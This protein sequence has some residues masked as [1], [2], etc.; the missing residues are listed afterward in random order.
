MEQE[1]ELNFWGEEWKDVVRFK[2]L[3]DTERYQISNYGR[4]RLWKPALKKWRIMKSACLTK[5]GTG[6]HYFTFKSNISW[7][8]TR[9]RAVHRLVAEAFLP[10]PSEFHK[11]V[12]HLDYNK[13]NNKALNLKWAT[14][15]MKTEHSKK[16]PKM[17]ALR[18][19]LTKQPKNQKLTSTD[20]IRLKKLLKRSDT[21]LY[22]IAKR[23]GI[24]HT[25]LNRIRKG[26]N[27]GHIKV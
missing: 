14:Q 15:K 16:S 6:Y 8:V 11:F 17:L 27:W 25:Q 4:V 26:E 24:T 18:N 21:P 23:F 20:V 9:S 19:G 5:D 2:G 7:K 10:C 3:H 1:K 13:A 22:K 12:I